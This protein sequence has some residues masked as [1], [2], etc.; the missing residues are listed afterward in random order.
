MVLW[1]CMFVNVGRITEDH[2]SRDNYARTRFS[3]TVPK[4]CMCSLQME[5]RN[6]RV[7][8]AFSY[9]SASAAGCFWLDD[10]LCMKPVKLQRGDYC[11]WLWG[12]IVCMNSLTTLR[13]GSWAKAT[14]IHYRKRKFYIKATLIHKTVLF[15]AG[16]W[17]TF[18]RSVSKLDHY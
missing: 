12:F 18:S 15:L 11:K 10:N 3:Y 9:W 7:C 13:Y 2:N 4:C 5:V 17:W 6:R 14:L 8:I 16:H 1:T